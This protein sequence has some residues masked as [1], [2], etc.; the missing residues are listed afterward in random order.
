MPIA[1]ALHISQTPGKSPRG[2]RDDRCQSLVDTESKID[3]KT[4]RW[5][6]DSPSDDQYAVRTKPPAPWT[7]GDERHKWVPG[8]YR[9]DD[10]KRCNAHFKALH[11]REEGLLKAAG[12]TRDTAPESVLEAL[13]SGKPIPGKPR[14]EQP[15]WL[16]AA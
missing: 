16:R 2:L 3:G 10:Q 8:S 1:S 15:R 12:W 13:T 6:G 9:S 14:R 11:D 5:A 7:W 4:A